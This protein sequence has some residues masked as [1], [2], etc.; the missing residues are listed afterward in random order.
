MYRNISRRFSNSALILILLNVLVFIVQQVYAPF[1]SMFILETADVLLRPWTV[2][3]SMFMHANALHLVFNMYALLIFGR[4]MEM[5]VGTKRFLF[6]YFL[7][8]LFAGVGFAVFQELILGKSAAA[9][10]A[11]GA[12]MG[13]LGLTIMLMPDLKVLFFFVIPMSMRTAGIIF[14][15]MDIFGL[16]HPYGVANMA[17]LVGLAVGLLC[18]W[19][20][21]GKKKEYKAK[22]DRPPPRKKTRKH[23]EVIHMDSQDIEDYYK[24]GRI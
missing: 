10:G 8:G 6:V 9:L 7:S 22:L 19:Y 11:S 1:N 4:L 13:I 23:G 14:A 2:L 15:A 3:T 5:R 21:L 18:G 20:L 24:Y 12:V 17:H 16:F